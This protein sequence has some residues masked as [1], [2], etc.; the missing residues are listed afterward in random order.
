[1]KEL[2]A[3]INVARW[4][5]SAGFVSAHV[6]PCWE[7]DTKKNLGKHIKGQRVERTYLG[8]LSFEMNSYVRT[9]STSALVHL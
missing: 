1:M 3:S 5:M 6:G 8:R 9:Y 4:N 2:K 7:S